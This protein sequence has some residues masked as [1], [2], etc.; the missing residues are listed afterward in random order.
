VKVLGTEILNR[1]IRGHR[2]LA[3]PIATW[4]AIAKGAKWNNLNELRRTWRNTDCVK[5]QTIFNVKGNKYRMLATLNYQSQT[6]VVRDVLTHADYD[7][8]KLDQ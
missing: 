6:I 5:G 8:M 7:R 1:A 4:L 3:G 2:D